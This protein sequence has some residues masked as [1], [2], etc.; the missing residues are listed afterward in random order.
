[1]IEDI[2]R[3][4]VKEEINKSLTALPKSEPIRA[5]EFLSPAGV[6]AYFGIPK[7]T[8]A[9]LR[10]S[11]QGPAFSRRGRVITYKKRDVEEY[12]NSCRV[13]TAFQR[14]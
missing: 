2:I 7:S 5:P 14:G 1:M 10:C 9:N 6:E 3:E 12:I 13:R 11:G 4:I 8:L